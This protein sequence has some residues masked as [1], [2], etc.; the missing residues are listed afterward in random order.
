MERGVVL[1]HEHATKAEQAYEAG[2]FAEAVR[3]HQA[4]AE[5]FSASTEQTADV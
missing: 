4:A 2:E 5:I 1:A 3:H